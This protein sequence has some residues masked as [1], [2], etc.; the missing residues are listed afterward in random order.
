[1]NHLR[2]VRGVS[3]RTL[4]A[5]RR[6]L[7][8]VENALC[9]A[10]DL[11]PLDWTRVS[12]D[13]L[14]RWMGQERRRGIGSRSLAR[15]LSAL[16]SFFAFLQS[17]GYRED[18]PSTGLRSPRLRRALPRVPSESIVEQILEQPELETERGRRDRAILELLYGCGLRLSEVVG[19]NLGSIDLPGESLR[20]LGKGSKE[21]ILPLVGEAKFR[22]ADYLERRLP[23][24]VYQG[25]VQG[26][27]ERQ[28]SGAPV[29]LGR[30]S[31]RIAPRT[32]QAMLQRTLRSALLGTGIS[33]HDLR[34]AF[35]THLLDRGADL[36]GVQELLGHASLSTTQI[37]T[38]L[39]SAR[40]AEVYRQ[41][42]PRAGGEEEDS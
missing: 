32:V 6:D 23:Q 29:F 13:D 3:T 11:S 19:M 22:L 42:H 7:E 17:M 31:A 21:R 25:M 4:E 20:V 38:H 16:R 15:R 1:M 37:Y 40:L 33:P 9:P 14:R 26:S 18:R 34:H 12:A 27:L 41:A 5:Y 24:T 39:S 30:G 28:E 35:A 8:S 10:D 2:A 36:R